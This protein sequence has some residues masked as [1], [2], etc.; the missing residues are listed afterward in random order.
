[1]RRCESH[2]YVHWTGWLSLNP[3]FLFFLP[4]FFTRNITG[5]LFSSLVFLWSTSPWFC[6]CVALTQTRNINSFGGTDVKP[7]CIH[8]HTH[9]QTHTCAS[10]QAPPALLLQVVAGVEAGRLRHR[11]GRAAGRRPIGGQ[12]QGGAACP[13]ASPLYPA[14]PLGWGSSGYRHGPR[15]PQSGGGGGSLGRLV[16]VV[17]QLQHG[18]HAGLCAAGLVLADLRVQVA[19]G[20]LELQTLVGALDAGTA[21]QDL[22]EARAEPDRGGTHVSTHA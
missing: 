5:R 6:L 13:P 3:F 16:H 17:G 12:V 1:M 15:R 14:P 20:G 2:E 22:L 7:K 9:T 19:R 11:L 21:A 10:R 8:T 18:G 4:F